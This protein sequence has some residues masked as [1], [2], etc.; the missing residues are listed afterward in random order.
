MG[1]YFDGSAQAKAGSYA[2]STCG[3]AVEH[4]PAKRLRGFGVTV[5][6]AGNVVERRKA[7]V[8]GNR[9]ELK[10]AVVQSHVS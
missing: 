5:R 8:E 6:E 3:H 4:S 2:G 10:E 7:K 1:P 9:A